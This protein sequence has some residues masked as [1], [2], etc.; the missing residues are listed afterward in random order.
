MPSKV[1]LPPP[2]ET[3]LRRR[4]LPV[5]YSIIS[6]DLSIVEHDPSLLVE[7]PSDDIP[8][9]ICVFGKSVGEEKESGEVEFVGEVPDGFASSE[10][11]SVSMA[12]RFGGGESIDAGWA[13]E[14]VE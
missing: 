9:Q 6:D 11:L 5:R 2:V 12:L 3:R 10:E 4:N 8:V 7:L 1:R 14:D 13:G